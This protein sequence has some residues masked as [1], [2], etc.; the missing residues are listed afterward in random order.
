MVSFGERGRGKTRPLF[1]FTNV[2]FR[3]N[4]EKSQIGDAMQTEELYVEPIRLPPNKLTKKTANETAKLVHGILKQ[5]A[6]TGKW[7]ICLIN[8][9]TLR[10]EVRFRVSGRQRQSIICVTKPGDNSSAWEIS[11][12]PP[13]GISLETIYSDLRSVPPSGRMLIPPSI[14]RNVVEIMPNVKALASQPIAMVPIPSIASPP[15]EEKPVP[16]ATPPSPVSV[17]AVT[18]DAD[19]ALKTLMGIKP[20]AKEAPVKATQSNPLAISSVA[21]RIGDDPTSL[22]H[23]LIALCMGMNPQDGSI[24]RANAI[25][26]LIQ[27]LAINDFVRNS[28]YTHPIKTATQLMR[29]LVDK[30]YVSRWT[31]TRRK[32]GRLR[33]GTKAYLLTPMGRQQ[34]LDLTPKMPPEVRDRLWKPDRIVFNTV[35][36]V[37]DEDELED[38]VKETK[39]TNSLPVDKVTQAASLFEEYRIRSKAVDDCKAMLAEYSAKKTE[40]LAQIDPIH[41]KITEY[42]TEIANLEASIKDLQKQHTDVQRDIGIMEQMK[43][44]EIAGLEAVK[45]KISKIM[46]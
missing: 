15:K 36:D 10:G 21:T 39:E 3:S 6:Y 45:S 46:G 9:I 26:L 4:M 43:R 22:N 5:F 30:G 11:L 24:F 23:G 27:E 1:S 16:I 28:R 35:I 41:S 44:E 42:R 31:A 19:D 40:L 34:L 33:E 12:N 18:I 14:G 2:N 8:R 37:P 20:I 25:R 38:D 13:Q 32:P 29:G 17:P 7:T